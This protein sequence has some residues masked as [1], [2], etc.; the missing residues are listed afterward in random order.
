MTW[1]W[2]VPAALAVGGTGLLVGAA[3]RAAAEAAGLTREVARFSDLRPALLA[4]RDLTDETAAAA[5]RL[6]RPT[7]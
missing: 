4:V 1:L 3:R 5:R 7:R 2:V 6:G